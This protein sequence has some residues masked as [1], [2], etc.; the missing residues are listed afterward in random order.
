[1]DRRQR[2]GGSAPASQRRVDAGERQLLERRRREHVILALRPF[3]HA[4]TRRFARP[5][6]A[7]G[8]RPAAIRVALHRTQN[9]HRARRRGRHPPLLGR[10]I[11]YEQREQQE[12]GDARE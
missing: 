8:S 2:P 4:E 6:L 11:V 7:P 1:M 9:H 5:G 12:R 10:T 3:E